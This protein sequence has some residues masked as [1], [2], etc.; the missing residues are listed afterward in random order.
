LNQPVAVDRSEARTRT[1]P[2]VTVVVPVFNGERFLGQALDSVRAQDYGPIEALVVD[3]GSTDGSARVAE[4]RSARTLRR[5][6]EGVSA[7]R[8]AGIAAAQG[9][10]VAFLDADDVLTVDAVRK[11]AEYLGDH[12][13]VG[14]VVA[15]ALHFV[16]PNSPLPSWFNPRYGT[17]PMVAYLPM[18]RKDVFEQVGVF[19][20]TYAIGE[21]LDWVT[22]A[23]DAGIRYHVLPDVVLSYRLHGANA[24]YSMIGAD[25]LLRVLRSSLARRRTDEAADG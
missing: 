25:H 17:E 11:Q 24:T 5:P 12:P 8:N 1:S 22:R 6:H 20:P 2:L 7:A 16:E 13:D 10:L 4:E 9:E 3:D 15:H 19:D 23:K 21:D 18:V 14:F